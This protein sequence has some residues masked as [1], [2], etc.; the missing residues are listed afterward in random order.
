MKQVK[1]I[2]GKYEGQIFDGHR[3]FYDYQYTGSSPDLFTI[4]TPDGD[5]T[6]T[7]DKIDVKHYEAQLLEEQLN[8]L[9][10]NVG[11]TVKIIRSGSGSY[12]RGWDDKAL[13]K[14]TKITSSGYVQFDDG[15]AET[16]RPDVE[17]VNTECPHY[18]Y[19]EE[20]NE[21]ICHADCET[22]CPDEF[23]ETCKY[24]L[25]EE[26]KEDYYGEFGLY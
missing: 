10:A 24:E 12:R 13:H 16:F 20:F 18:E 7:S 11:D 26:V 8:R 1:V 21:H 2:S 6:I 4:K 5:I 19:D 14:I 22:M 9:G 15:L 23:R 25:P 17:V 3:F